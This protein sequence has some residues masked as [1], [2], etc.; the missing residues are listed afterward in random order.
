MEGIKEARRRLETRMTRKSVLE[1]NLKIGARVGGFLNGV[2]V[3][4]FREICH[5]ERPGRTCEIPETGSSTTVSI[6]YRLGRDATF[7]LGACPSRHDS[8]GVH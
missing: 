1:L 5:S 6:R 3:Y 7:Q 2:S 4:V 8:R